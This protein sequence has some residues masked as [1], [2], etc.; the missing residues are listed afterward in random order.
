[1]LLFLFI[2]IAGHYPICLIAFNY[3]AFTL[4]IISYFIFEFIRIVLICSVFVVVVVV[5]DIFYFFGVYVDDEGDS[6]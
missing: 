3:E 5:V 2:V 6:Q 1:M 4:F